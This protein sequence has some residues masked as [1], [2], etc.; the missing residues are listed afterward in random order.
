MDFNTYQ[1]KAHEFATYDGNDYPKFALV[2]EVGEL[3]KIFAK[4]ARGD[5]KYT[6]MSTD[7]LNGMISKEAGDILWELSEVLTQYGIKLDDVASGNISKLTD[8]KLRNVI[9]GDGDVR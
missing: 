9:K 1:S 5:V 4:L 7:E 3:N 8:R 6:S 2:E